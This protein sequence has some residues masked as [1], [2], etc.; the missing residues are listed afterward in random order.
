MNLRHSEGLWDSYV[1]IFIVIKIFIGSC[2]YNIGLSAG[3][4]IVL[5][6][7][8]DLPCVPESIP[9]HLSTFSLSSSLD[10]LRNG[11]Q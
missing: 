8:Y 6:L 7:L 5:Y 4:I 2:L 3:G 9:K 10:G 11:V 1:L